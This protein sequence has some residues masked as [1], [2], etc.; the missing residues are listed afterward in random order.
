MCEDDDDNDEALSVLSIATGTILLQEFD[1][2]SY[3]LGKMM[4]EFVKTQLNKYFSRLG[5]QELLFQTCVMKK[6]EIHRNTQLG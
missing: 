1:S 4:D 5:C 3:D 2:K 6:C